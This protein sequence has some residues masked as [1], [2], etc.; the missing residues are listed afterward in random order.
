MNCSLC[1]DTGV[2]I[3]YQEGIIIRRPCRCGGLTP[4]RGLGRIQLTGR[5]GQPP[6]QLYMCSAE[7]RNS[8]RATAIQPVGGSLR[9]YFGTSTGIFLT[10]QRPPNGLNWLSALFSPSPM[11]G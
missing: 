6:T 4:K 5:P 3:L 10:S 8:G 9:S 1:Q 11:G 2:V 7:V